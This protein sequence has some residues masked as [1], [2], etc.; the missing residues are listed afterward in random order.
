MTF[1]IPQAW[2]RWLYGRILYVYRQLVFSDKLFKVDQNKKQN[3]SIDK[4]Q[5]L[6][7][8]EGK[9]E[10]ALAKIQVTYLMQDMRRIFYSNL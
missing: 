10:K 3:R 4:V 2:K 1:Y 7:K 9:Y 8:E 6:G 5:N